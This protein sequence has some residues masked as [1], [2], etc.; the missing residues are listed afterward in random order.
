MQHTLGAI[1]VKGKTIAVLG[2]GP[3]YIYPKE[4][5]EIYSKI[6]ETGGAIVSEYPEGTEPESERFRQ[7]NRIVSGL[8]IGIL[9]VEAKTRSGTGITVKY[10]KSQGKNVFCIPSSIENKKGIGTNNQIKKGA[11]LVIEPKEILEK[12]NRINIKQ[13][14]L[15]ELNEKNEVDLLKLNNIKEEYRSIY[16]ALNKPLS[17]EEI[18][19]KTGLVITEVYSKIFMM[20]LDEL[21]EYKEN[22]YVIKKE[23]DI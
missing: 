19:S 20:E 15:E 9:V 1:E 17:I 21:I 4:N 16:K 18:S 10:A 3:D 5:K 22:K 13:I 23:K 7:R 12:Y 6:L 2:N 8:S 14:T 11:T